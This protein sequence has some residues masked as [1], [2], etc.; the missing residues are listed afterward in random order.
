MIYTTSLRGICFALIFHASVAIA[1]AKS[2]VELPE[3]YLASVVGVTANSSLVVKRHDGTH[4]QIVLA[5]ITIPIGDQPYAQRSRK[6]LQHQLTGRQIS[7]RP[8]STPTAAYTQAVIYIDTNN[9]NID[10]VYR[11]H[12]WV[13][14]Y[15]RNTQTY[16]KAQRSAVANGRGLY[17]DPT[18]KH[19][20]AWKT[21]KEQAL[22]LASSLDEMSSHPRMKTVLNKT[23]VGHRSKKIFVPTHCIAVWSAWP[24]T[25]HSVITT[26]AGAAAD[27]YSETSCE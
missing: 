19:P 27:G 20:V 23:Y 1:D 18:A 22:E 21:Q 9:F 12:A 8:T 5:H 11:G 4:H 2:Y 16:L 6:I 25:E 24:Q 14:F 7:V 15:N 26:R 17:A 10:M 13:D 3:P